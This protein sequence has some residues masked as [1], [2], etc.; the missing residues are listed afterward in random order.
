MNRLF[1]IINSLSNSIVYLHQQCTFSVLVRL[2][3][4]H[5]M[6]KKYTFCIGQPCVLHYLL[7]L[8]YTILY[9]L[10]FVCTKEFTDIVQ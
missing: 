4:H 7:N 1:S 2:V 8:W 5:I 9:A 3:A 6:I 10:H